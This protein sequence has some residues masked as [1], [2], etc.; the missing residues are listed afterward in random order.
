[1][2]I[3]RLIDIHNP[4]LLILQETMME[5]DTTEKLFSSSLPGWNFIGL[6]AYGKSSSPLMEW[7]TH[8]LQL[9][10]SWAMPFVL[11][12]HFFS[13]SHNLSF[14]LLNTYGPYSDRKTLWDIL[15][16]STSRNVILEG[17]LNFTLGYF[18]IW[19][20]FAFRDPLT[21]YFIKQLEDSKLLDLHP[22]KLL[23]T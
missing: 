17:D 15:F 14:L 13:P 1:L 23:P 4:N 19:G 3:R 21:D 22:L 8:S 7:R 10:N 20:P 18:E 12:T 2:A 5:G 9:T 6:D 16:F 11:G